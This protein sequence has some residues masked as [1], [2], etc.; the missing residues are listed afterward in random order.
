VAINFNEASR[1]WCILL[2]TMSWQHFPLIKQPLSFEERLD[3]L[4]LWAL[5]ERRNWADLVHVFKLFKGLPSTPFSHFFTTSTV[6]NTRS[7]T[8]KI[9][10]PRC[11]LD[12][13]RFFFSHRV[14]D[15]WNDLPQSVIDSS[16]TNT[17][18]NGL[19]S[20]TLRRNRIGLFMD[21]PVR[22]DHWPHQF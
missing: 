17:F 4:G 1:L 14:T 16:T 18:K 5:E 11:Q 10:K 3:R 6:T 12:L 13:R 22:L 9:M 7:H 19:N 15:R 8:A 2:S 20:N 21:Q